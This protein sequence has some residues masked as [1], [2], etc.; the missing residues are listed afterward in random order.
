MA[1][2]IDVGSF[3]V[4]LGPVAFFYLYPDAGAVTAGVAFD[5]YVFALDAYGHVVTDYAGEVFFWSP[6][7][8][9][10]FP[11]SYTFQPEDGGV[12]YL[13]EAV[14]FGTPGPQELYVFDA[15]CTALGVA[16]YE[17]L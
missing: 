11:A 9:A 3:E 16:I 2:A 13:P 5:L 8:A 15:A 17:V 4:Q 10:V 7:E 14:V 12:A 1:G 6:D